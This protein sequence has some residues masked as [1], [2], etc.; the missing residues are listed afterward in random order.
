M[1][2]IIIIIVIV[3]L[4]ILN[5]N[6][7]NFDNI[8]IEDK[9]ENKTK[10][11]LF[12]T[13]FDKERIPKDVY[14]NIKEY[15]P[16]YNHVVY[17]DNDIITFLKK[18]YNQNVIDTFINLKSG[19]HKADLARYCLLY[20]HG[21][22]YMDIKTKLIKPLKEIFT[23][24]DIIYSVLSNDKDHIYQG[25]ISTP[26]KQ[27]LFL[28]L[29]NFIIRI[30]NPSSYHLFCKDFYYNI[31]DDVGYIKPGLLLGKYNKYY[32]FQEKCSTTDIAMC[33]NKTDKYGLCCYI[34]DG[35]NPIIKTRRSSFPW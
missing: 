2:I 3:L 26:P 29:I 12:Q 8:K 5:N 27:Y 22:V 16:E 32:L 31:F 25:V 15:A 7:Q 21:G 28:K 34:Y 30:Q 1:L 23:E 18:Y 11:Y 10:K 33:N 6:K 35:N 9:I 24:N 20:I 14:T 19:A 4:T 17:D 13:Y